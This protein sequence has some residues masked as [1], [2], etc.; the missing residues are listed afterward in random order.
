[1]SR[2]RAEP[3]LRVE[4]ISLS[5]R[6]IHAIT[7][8]S[9]EIANGEICSL[10]GPNGAGKSSLL[11][12]MNGVYWPDSGA[13]VFDGQRFS[14]LGAHQAATLGIART[15]Q[16]NALFRRL[17]VLDNVLT[18]LS[19]HGRASVFDQ[20]FRLPAARAEDRKFREQAEDVLDFLQYRRVSRCD[21]RAA[22]VRPAEACRTGP[23]AGRR[24]RSSCCST[25]RWRA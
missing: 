12:V 9:F 3:L 19:R 18:G 6:G 23:R 11:N 24:A 1:M 21:R 17:S 5:F 14:G 4:D 8:L 13:V 15:F 22:A 2:A 20:V 16:N 25:S 10:I 7:S